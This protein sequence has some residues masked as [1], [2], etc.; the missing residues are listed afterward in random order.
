MSFSL[1]LLPPHIHLQELDLSS[2]GLSGAL[3][4]TWTAFPRLARLDLGGNAFTGGY[5]A[6]RVHAVR[7]N[8]KLVMILPDLG[9]NAFMGR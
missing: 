1:C 3:P 4:D 9:R 5:R 6:A 2:C 8:R 7:T